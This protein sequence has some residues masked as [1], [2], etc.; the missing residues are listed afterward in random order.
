MT[1]LITGATGLV[2]TRLLRRLVDAGVECRAVVRSDTETGLP[3]G[4]TPVVADL[5]EPETLTAATAG[6]TDVIHLAAVLRTP[7]P[8]LIQRVNVDG[9]NNLIAA[10]KA[11]APD[12]RL[13]MASTSLV[14]SAD[15]SRPGREDDEV[16]PSQPY[17]A[18]KIV[19]E[20][21]LRESG[22]N[23]SVLRFG[24]V[25]GEADG[26]LQSA[27]GLLG[28]WNWHPAATLNL[29]HHRDIATAMQ[30]ALAGSF[31]GRTVNITDD[32]PTTLIEISDIVG[33]E[34]A[35]SAEPLTNPWNGRMDGSLARQLGFVA[36]VPTVYQAASA[37]DL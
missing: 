30:H 37:N 31:D 4:V 36:T 15:Q 7:D 3:E 19:A 25:Y 16:N 26:H 6:V 10:V 29:V 34:Y 18:S 33:A 8:S 1:V 35:A 28:S 5:L 23:W 27:P 9:T 2:G 20:R 21:A 13:I 11:N 17:P 12:A 24:F 32:A 22:L 14:Y